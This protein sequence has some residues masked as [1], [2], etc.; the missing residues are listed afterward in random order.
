M[1]RLRVLVLLH[2]D[3]MPPESLKGVDQ[4]REIPLW[5]TE[6]DVARAL[7]ILGHEVNL[8][9]LG[10]ELA[11]IR[12]TV[13]E[14]EPHVVFN[15]LAHFHDVGLYGAYVVS[16]LEL[17]KLPYTGCNP[18]G[19]M[20]ADDKTLC[21]RMLQSH[22]IPTPRFSIVRRGSVPRLRRG[23]DFPLFV[24]SGVE[25]A[26]WGISQASIVHDEASLRERVRF[27]HQSIGSDAIVE[28]Y[29]EGREIYVGVMGNQR[30]QALPVWELRFEN[31]PEGSEPIAT[32]RA[33]WN[34]KYQE[35]V[36]VKSGRAHLDPEQALAIQRIAKRIYR[37]LGLSGCARIDLRLTPEG[38]IY[39]LEANANPELAEDEDF[40]L[41]A[42]AAGIEYTALI[43]RL[44]NL[45]LRYAP[46]WKT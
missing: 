38:Q 31:L 25:H 16:Y 1:R 36:G 35:R 11:P 13:E 46:A 27:V 39:V 17:L 22:R 7:E 2:E 18:R 45:G 40:A 21:K 12:R 34:R 19:M 20:L 44:I 23:L 26:S 15:L 6:Y 37:A 28:E 8:L 5:R 29:I 30:L 24:K 4:D 43:Q 3:L 42:H 9:G 14:W 41:S 10:E 33:K 32:H